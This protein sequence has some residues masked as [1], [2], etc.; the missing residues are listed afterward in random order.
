MENKLDVEYGY[1]EIVDI[2]ND[3]LGEP[4]NHNEFSGQISYDCPVCSYEIKG[5]DHTDGK[6]NLEINYKSGVYKCWACCD[7]HGTHGILRYFIKKHGTKK[8]LKTYDLLCPEDAN[9][10]KK[11][12]NPVRLPKDFIVF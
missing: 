4:K 9:K 11:Q 10:S 1:A 6:G 8:Q 3:I 2:L 12:Y 7:S 5:L